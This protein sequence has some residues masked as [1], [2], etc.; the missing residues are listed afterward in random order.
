MD[1]CKRVEI[2]VFLQNGIFCVFLQKGEILVIF[3]KGGIEW[4]SKKVLNSVDFCKKGKCLGFLQKGCY[5]CDFLQKEVGF[6]WFLQKGVRCVWFLQKRGGRW[7]FCTR[8]EIYGD[9]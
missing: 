2:L 5:S 7:D 6:L 4:V 8:G 3:A 9:L 1:C